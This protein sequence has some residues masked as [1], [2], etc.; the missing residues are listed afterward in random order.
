M[1]LINCVIWSS[2]HEISGESSFIFSTENEKLPIT[3]REKQGILWNFFG[4]EERKT[5]I[6]CIVYFLDIFYKS[7]CAERKGVV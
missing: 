6:F 5:D 2:D 1:G 4:K 7:G 3:E